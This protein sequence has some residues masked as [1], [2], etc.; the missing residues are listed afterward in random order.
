MRTVEEREGQSAEMKERLKERIDWWLEEGG[1]EYVLFYNSLA[2][3]QLTDI[4]GKIAYL[5]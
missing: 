5:S 1:D 2:I 4:N 3:L